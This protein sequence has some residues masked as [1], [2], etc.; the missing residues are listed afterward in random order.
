MITE[1]VIKGEIPEEWN[2]KEKQDKLPILWIHGDKDSLIG[3][4]AAKEV[5][6]NTI[7]PLGIK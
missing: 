1:K 6:E 4:E 5:V 2:I 7:K 3:L